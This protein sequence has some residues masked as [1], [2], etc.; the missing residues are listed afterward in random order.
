MKKLKS[1]FKLLG[2][3]AVALFFSN[4]CQTNKVFEH[5][6]SPNAN[7]GISNTKI[8]AMLFNATQFGSAIDNYLAGKVA[9]YSYNVIHDG[10]LVAAS[11]GGWARKWYETNP[12]KH[13]YHIRQGIAS[14]SKFVT[15]LTTIAVLEKYNIL[16]D[17]P[18][19]PY[20]PA[21]WKPSEAFKKVT[22]KRILQ[23]SAGLIRYGSS[24]ANMK[25]TVE[26]PIDESNF[27]N[28]SIVYDNLNYSLMAVILASLDIRK[29]GNISLSTLAALEKSG[30]WYTSNVFGAYFRGL[31]RV[32]V[33]K[34]ASLTYWSVVDYTT[35]NNNG[36]IPAEQ[37]T[38]GYASVWGTETGQLKGDSRL[39][40]G[41]GGLYISANEFGHIQ[42]AAA[43]GKI[44]SA[45]NYQR[46]K[47]EWL[48]FDGVLNGKYG[49][50]AWKN[51]A[52]NNHE[53]L[54]IDMGRTQVAIF[55]NS[56]ASDIGSSAGR[57]AIRDAYDAAW[58]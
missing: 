1:N 56:Q 27:S 58:K 55:C 51:G 31:A 43:E 29:T 18:V 9:G 44:I 23:H 22:F 40:G 57:N 50:Y 28:K 4:A 30:E 42:A 20:L 48:G 14:S 38:K 12:T 21:S 10:L 19:H 13:G 11:G 34:K 33:F 5:A 41:S 39:N 24:W 49:K 53:T 36:V 26:G 17:A 52:A 35:W 45:S 25:Q 15:A 8:G 47:N 37:G 54:I 3:V 7:Q 32:Y 6:N 2:Y 16:L 46:M